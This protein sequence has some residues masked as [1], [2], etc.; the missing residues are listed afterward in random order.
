MLNK[1]R[2]IQFAITA[3]VLLNLSA[4]G[5]DKDIEPVVVL[6]EVPPE[7]NQATV[8]N[9]P[10]SQKSASQA[11][12]FIKNG[13]YANSIAAATSDVVISTP[14][15]GNENSGDSNN[16][17]SQTNTIE[18][19]VDESDRLKYD[20]N[21][22]Y[23]AETSTYY[24]RNSAQPKVRVLKRND[25]FTLNSLP[26]IESSLVF[27]RIG[28]I[29]LHDDTLTMLGAIAEN[30]P[31]DNLTSTAYLPTTPKVAISIFDISNPEQSTESL[32]LE[33]DGVLLDT[34]RID[35]NLYIISSFVPGVDNLTL[36]ANNDAD[37]I[38]N[39]GTI[40]QTPI[41]Q[42]M[43][44]R[45]QDGQQSPLINAEDC[46]IPQQATNQDGNAQFLNITRI[47]LA[48]PTELQ[49]VCLMAV[50]NSVYMSSDNLYLAANVN[51]LESM[52][53][54]I[55]LSTLDYAASGSVQGQLGWRGNPLFRIHENN[56]L[57]RVVTSD[58]S[59]DEPSHRLSV[60]QQQGTE[61]IVVATLPNESAPDLIGKPGEDI[62]AVRFIDEKAYIVTFENIDP[63][64][65]INL[66]DGTNPFIEGELEIP[67]FS[68]YIHPLDN[69][70]LLGIGQQ[71]ALNDLPDI[72]VDDIVELPQVSGMKISLFD[73]RD[74]A[75][76]L[77]LTSLVTPSAYTPV[78][79]D[80]KALSVLNVDGRYQ[81]ALPI[82]EWNDS[83]PD[84][85]ADFLF[86]AKNSLL[87]L[88]TDTTK[89]LPE[90]LL[91][92]K[93]TLPSNRDFYFFSGDDRSI[94]QGDKVYYLRGNSVWLSDW[95]QDGAASGPY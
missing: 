58:Y 73:V 95:S 42:L 67:G 84:F 24:L 2:F 41:N 66:S 71:V 79:F 48:A 83:G 10:L 40:T 34:R 12:Q 15:L 26:S 36:G 19:G 91:I 31:I 76:P 81:F 56:G 86:A 39:Y 88:E 47:N 37:K 13:I 21:Y 78:E 64:Y 25:D 14:S 6:P 22:M 38:N 92:N 43:P 11:E 75:N 90:L 72:G 82:E 23:V 89:D 32:A 33:L 5:S 70:Y 60:L 8:F 55:E 28:G 85:F 17:F 4:C 94:I 49:S 69:G 63:L 59:Q 93:F 87:M 52:F 68:S 27:E 1:P 30:Y 65:V 7:V 74:P 57:L 3:F 20:G 53:H 61:L 29:Y 9:G 54:K 35:N 46:Y 44:Q 18:Q 51:N 16:N 80:Y 45:Y 62:Y 50:A 77:E